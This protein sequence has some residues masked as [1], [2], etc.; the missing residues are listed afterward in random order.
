MRVTLPNGAKPD[1]EE[2]RG[3]VEHPRQLGGADALGSHWRRGLPAG[4]ACKS[5]P[6]R[7][8]RAQGHPND[9]QRQRRSDAE[10]D[11]QS[12]HGPRRQTGRSFAAHGQGDPYG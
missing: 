3:V 12:R 2:Q 11:G 7:V 5:I 9:Q 4:G 8:D 6:H 1:V 10:T